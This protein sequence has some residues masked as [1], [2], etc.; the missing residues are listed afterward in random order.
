[1]TYVLLSIVQ[2]Y[3]ILGIVVALCIFILLIPSIHYVK[4]DKVA[5]VETLRKEIKLYSGRWFFSAPFF[6]RYLFSL[7]KGEITI[8]Q[9]FENKTYTLVYKIVDFVSFSTWNR[10]PIEGMKTIFMMSV[11]ILEKKRVKDPI[12]EIKKSLIESFKESL[13]IEIIDVIKKTKEV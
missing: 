7:P 4:L 5:V 10:V 8:K 13:P 11:L 9:D 6:S 1:M 2:T 3:I 12:P